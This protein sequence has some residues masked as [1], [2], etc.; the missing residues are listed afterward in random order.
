MSPVATLITDVIMELNCVLLITL[1]VNRI[2]FSL[3][4]CILGKQIE[5]CEV[6][7][8]TTT[9]VLQKVQWVPIILTEAPVRARRRGGTNRVFASTSLKKGGKKLKSFFTL[10]QCALSSIDGAYPG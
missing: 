3:I 2:Y 1:V 6:E 9:A 10:C 5:E 8:S 7:N 4:F